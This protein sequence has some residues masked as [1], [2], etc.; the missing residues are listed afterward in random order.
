MKPQSMKSM[1]QWSFSSKNI[2]ESLKRDPRITMTEN[3]AKKLVCEYEAP[4]SYKFFLKAA[5]HLSEAFIWNT[6]ETSKKSARIKS[7]IRYFIKSC[8]NEMQRTASA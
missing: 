7:P 1:S 2:N 8:Q 5:W 3:T 4:N 6:V